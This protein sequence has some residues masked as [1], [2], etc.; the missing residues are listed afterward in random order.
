MD[1]YKNFILFVVI[2]FAFLLV[3]LFFDNTKLWHIL[4]IIDTS[5]AV[6]LAIMA[7]F[8]YY[9]FSKG[10]D[11]IPL[12]FETY[13]EE[14]KEKIPLKIDGEMVYLL[15]ENVQRAEV[16]GILGIVQNDM[17]GKFK[18][19]DKD[20]KNLLKNIEEVQ[21]NKKNELL[22]PINKHTFNEFFKKENK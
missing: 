9:E 5:T 21:L 12:Y 2:T 10:K 6:A 4:T 8:A 20:T 7:L 16:M 14:K 3:G 18:L 15:R 17:S 1:K 19:N 13:D 22:I 11:K